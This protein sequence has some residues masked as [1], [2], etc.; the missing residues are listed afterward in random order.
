MKKIKVLLGTAVLVSLL[1][2]SSFASITT[3]PKGVQKLDSADIVDALNN[4]ADILDNHVDKIASS[5]IL[6]HVKIGTGLQVSEDGTANV[7]IA[8]DLETDDSETALSA[9]M[10]KELSDAISAYTYDIGVSDSNYSIDTTFTSLHYV[11]QIAY[12]SS[13]IR[14]NGSFLSDEYY[15]VATTSIYPEKRTYLSCAYD[16]AYGDNVGIA[17]AYI[18][19]DGKIYV[20]IDETYKNPTFYISGNFFKN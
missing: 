11:N 5:D 15:H 2:F 10:G 18:E 13:A 12:I 14:Y 16:N 20:A 3:T 6:G 1:G 9:A 19:P 4:N 7:K 8:N 17:N